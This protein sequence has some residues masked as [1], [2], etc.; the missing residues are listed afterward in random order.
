MSAGAKTC[1]RCKDTK[2]CSAFTVERGTWG[3]RL[4][5]WC[6]QCHAE[7][8][9]EHGRKETQR[10]P[11]GV[12]AP[13]YAHIVAKRCLWCAE[14]KAVSDFYAARG[15]PSG[16]C[17]ACHYAYYR[18]RVK[19]DPTYLRDKQRKL[20]KRKQALVAA[21]KTA[22]GCTDCG[23]QHPAVLDYH[24]N[25]PAT[26]VAT[27]AQL[28]LNNGAMRKVRAEMAKC[29]VLC[30]NCHRKRHWGERYSEALRDEVESPVTTYIK[31]AG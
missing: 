13:N 23:E 25:D 19:E 15:R 28:T 14:V 12:L 8:S 24:H 2:P 1:S 21:M 29:T 9:K 6:K 17:K 18:K 16:H 5:S 11:A 10:F 27:V 20:Q 30:A 26:K 22:V 7:Y 4:G 3:R 31:K